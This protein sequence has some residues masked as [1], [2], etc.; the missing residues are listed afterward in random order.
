MK[1]KNIYKNVYLRALLVLSVSFISSCSKKD[2]KPVDPLVS[3]GKSVYM[4]NCTA[5]HN[6]DPQLV[7][8]IGPD[9][10]G[11]S[12]ELVMSRVVHQSYPPGYAPKRKTA[13][14][15]PLPFLEKDVPAIHAY[16]NSFK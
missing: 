3:R 6:S 12:L 4:A 1:Q 2:D 7:G 16:L 13:L 15:P 11:S 14:M 9:I 10:A 8:S 5:C